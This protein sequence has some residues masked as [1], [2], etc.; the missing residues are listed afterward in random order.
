MPAPTVIARLPRALA[1]AL[2]AALAGCN[3]G[4]VATKAAPPAASG[5]GVVSDG[6]AGGGT[7]GGAGPAA[8]GAAVAFVGAA[9]AGV[10]PLRAPTLA[11][12]PD[13]PL[14]AAIRRGHAL[15]LATRDSL[16]GHVGNRLRC[17]SCHLDEGRRPRSAPFVGVYG[18]FPQY[19]S[20][21]GSV[22]SVEDRINGCFQRSLNG[23]PLPAASRAMRD[24]VAYLAFVSRG[25]PVGARVE[26]QGFGEVP[27]L[28]P[29]TARGAR[30]FATA[31]A[32][33]HGADGQG[34]A[35]APPVWGP[36]SYNIGA[37]MARP[38][39]AAAFIRWN[40]PFDRPGSLSDQ[41]AVDVAYYI[42]SK[43]RPDYAPK[44]DDWP[45]GDPPAD[46][47]YATKAG[48]RLATRA[49]P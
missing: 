44:A 31:C 5:A 39:T 16:P 42:D 47:P 48:R 26:G 45:N 1:L 41:D 32:R 27:A 36:D 28:E 14:G 12:A 37:G 29:D 17:V 38:R 10:V 40:M 33:C 2:A 11:E 21:S 19:R 9:A 4:D 15:M 43:P 18:Q 20:R 7:A 30:I 6:A 22:I 8:G 34:T 49:A 23:K 13:G 46:L 24:M 25:V 35:I 3:A